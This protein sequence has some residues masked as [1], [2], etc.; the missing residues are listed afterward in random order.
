M[1]RFV[2]FLIAARWPLFVVAMVLAAVA[3]WPAGQVQFDR[4]I[5]KMFAPDDPVLPPYQR[6]KERF[7]GNE[8][9]VAVYHDDH[10]MDADGR[11]IRRL[12][13][14]S[15]QL[16]QV[17]GVRDVLSLSE[18]SQL[19]KKLEKEKQP[20]KLLNIFGKPKE[21][22]QGEA[23]LDP[24][25]ALAARFR[26]LFAGYTHSADGTTAAVVCM[27]EPTRVVTAAATED[28]RAV[29]IAGL[30]KVVTALPDG[31]E[32]GVL[33]GEPVMVHEGFSLLEEDGE[34]L[35]TWTT[36][37]LGLTILAPFRHPRW[38]IIPIFV[39]QWTLIITR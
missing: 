26:E 5:E 13:N 29:T 35:G 2:E 33:A 27:L 21:E 12:A 18:I 19:L 36:L 34:K 39:V 8:I 30:E 20:L 1:Q 10:L 9:V 17:P 23:I 3:W 28:P 32:P 7:G 38:L 22:W 4:S 15:E 11:G 31:L 37:L 25:S 14:V 24:A 16:R 6:L